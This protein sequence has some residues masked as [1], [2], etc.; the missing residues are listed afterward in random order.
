MLKW[1]NR[2]GKLLLASHALRSFAYGFL[3]VVIVIYLKLIGIQELEIGIVITATLISSA[4]FT[5]IASVYADR[6]GRRRI[7]ILFSALMAASGIIFATTANYVFL[8]IAALVG[9]INVTGTEVGPFLSVEQAMLPQTCS[10]RRRTKAFSLYSTSGKLAV[11]SGA[12]V[13]GLPEFFQGA[14][15]MS[16]TFSFKPLFILYSVFALSAIGVYLLYSKRVEAPDIKYGRRQIL[17]P[18]SRR[19]VSRLSLLF[20]VDSFAGG[21]VL[22]SIVAYWFFTKFQISL[23]SISVIFFAANILTAISFLIAARIA[24]R[25]G[26][27][28]TMVFTHIPSN[29]F[30]ILVPLAPSLASALAFYLARMSLSQMDVPTRQ[31]YI[32]AIVS[33]KE[34][35]AAAGLTNTSRNISQAVSPSITGYIFQFVSLSFPF[36]IGGGLKIIYDLTLYFNFRKIKP[37]EELNRSS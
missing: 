13:G 6:L 4:L 36:L 5:L 23:S 37:P 15:G 33:P 22:Q 2:D 32:V 26:L 8:L 35:T 16:P 3:S 12:L 34:R 24:D 31:S 19:R 20:A 28:R 11:A 9:T 1:L 10:D 21:F 7:L 25:V 18:E 29:I 27:I 17:E 30:L 14:F